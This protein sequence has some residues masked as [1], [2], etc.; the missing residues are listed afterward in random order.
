L[1]FHLLF[2]PSCKMALFLRVEFR[3]GLRDRTDCEGKIV[4]HASGSVRELRS[5]QI[6]SLRSSKKNQQQPSLEGCC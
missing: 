2:V 5:R 6:T 4:E 3:H 1:K